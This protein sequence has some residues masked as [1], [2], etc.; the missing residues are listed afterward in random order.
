VRLLAKV[1]LVI[2]IIVL[3]VIG[4][5]ALSG[6][7]A[8][9][10]KKSA[11]VVVIDP[12]PKES[13]VIPLRGRASLYAG[14]PKEPTDV[15]VPVDEAEEVNL[16]A[17]QEPRFELEADDSDGTTFFVYAWMEMSDFDIYCDSIALPKMR[18][19]REGDDAGWV[20]AETGERLEMLRVPLRKRCES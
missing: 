18:Y 13:Q 7:W 4:V 17:A 3:F 20:D 11:V 8:G 2:G 9:E 10:E 14:A 6:W 15:D 1:G 5:Q 16:E 12:P 19:V